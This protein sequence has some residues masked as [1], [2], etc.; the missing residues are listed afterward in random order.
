[1]CFWRWDS[2]LAGV[3]HHRIAEDGQCQS[4]IKSSPVDNQVKT[5]LFSKFSF[6]RVCF[7]SIGTCFSVLSCIVS[8]LV[9]SLII[10]PRCRLISC[11][12]GRENTFLS[13]KWMK[14]YVWFF[15]W[16]FIFRETLHHQTAQINNNAVL[17]VE[18]NVVKLKSPWV[19]WPFCVHGLQM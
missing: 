1:M 2:F 13:A 17:R 19:G 6:F 8:C 12:S 14:V 5:R 18:G 10:E 16:R 4:R 9:V 11:R 15:L 7:L 3:T